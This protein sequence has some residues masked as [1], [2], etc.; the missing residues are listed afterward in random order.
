MITRREAERSALTVASSPWSESAFKGH[1]AESMTLF[2]LLASA[3]LKTSSLN[4]VQLGISK[5]SNP[6]IGGHADK[7]AWAI[8][9]PANRS[10]NAS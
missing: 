5:R 8:A 1:N 7:F 4:C 9:M 2:G 6:M 10:F 3:H